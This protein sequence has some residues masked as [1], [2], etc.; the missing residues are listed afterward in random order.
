MRKFAKQFGKTGN[1]NM[2]NVQCLAVGFLVMFSSTTQVHEFLE[3]L[4]EEEIAQLWFQQEGTE[5]QTARATVCN[6]LFRDKII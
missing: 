5:C 1:A 6:L 4:A 2:T 3:Q